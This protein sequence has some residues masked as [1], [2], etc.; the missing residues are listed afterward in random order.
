MSRRGTEQV[1]ALV[2]GDL[3]R[4]PRAVARIT[5]EDKVRAVEEPTRGNHV[6][7]GPHGRPAAQ[8]DGVPGRRRRARPRPAPHLLRRTPVGAPLP[9]A[10]SRPAPWRRPPPRQ[11]GR[12]GPGPAAPAADPAGGP[13]RPRRAAARRRQPF[14]RRFGL[15]AARPPA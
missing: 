2:A 9:R 10:P 6:A 15:A 5:Q 12:A 8:V 4:R 14:L 13:D 3:P 11:G 7:R 1:A